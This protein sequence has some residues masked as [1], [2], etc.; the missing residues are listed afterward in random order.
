MYFVIWYPILLVS[1]SQIPK[2]TKMIFPN[3]YKLYRTTIIITKISTYLH[4]YMFLLL[5][6]LHRCCS[7]CCHLDALTWPIF[8]LCI[9]TLVFVCYLQWKKRT[10]SFTKK[11]V[12]NIFYLHIEL[13]VFTFIMDLMMTIQFED[14]NQ[15][16]K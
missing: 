9:E 14:I 11:N 4:I 8:L 3:I 1:K 15:I 2:P 16:K 10:F 6:G 12:F 5:F 7:I 13:L